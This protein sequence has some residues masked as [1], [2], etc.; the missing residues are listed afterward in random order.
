M[1]Q[2]TG[3]VRPDPAEQGFRKLL[4]WQKA[5]DLAAEV[6]RLTEKEMDARHRWLSLQIVRAAF[7][8]TANI[9]EGYGR[10]SLAD[11]A[12]FLEVAGASLNE[13]ENGLHF[14]RRNRV[15]AP[16]SLAAAEELRRVTG[17][18]LFGLAR[19]LRS[20]LTNKE[21]WQRGLVREQPEDYEPNTWVDL[22]FQVPGSKFPDP[23]GYHA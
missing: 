21:D 20:K 12:R 3:R 7:S 6:F 11:Y 1:E 15:L 14:T 10:S 9:A 5:D 2:G 13:V 19:S 22:Q 23:E 17:N 18:L 16:E 8:V 4:A